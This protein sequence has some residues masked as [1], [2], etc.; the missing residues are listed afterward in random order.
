MTEMEPSSSTLSALIAGIYDRAVDPSLWPRTLAGI[1]AFTG[2]ASGGLAVNELPTGRLLMAQGHGIAPEWVARFEAYRD[3]VLAMWGGPGTAATAAMDEVHVN[4]E[5]MRG[6]RLENFA[7]YREYYRPQG[8]VDAAMLILARDSSLIATLGLNWPEGRGP[9]SQ[10]QRN[11]LLLLLPHLQRAM[12]ISNLLDRQTLAQASLTATLNAIGTGIVLVAPDLH[13]VF[14]NDSGKLALQD[15]P[16]L[17]RSNGRLFVDEP[18]AMSALTQAVRLAAQDEAVIGLRGHGIPVQRAG[19][20]ALVLHVLPL[21]RSPLRGGLIPEAGAAV[22]IS[23]LTPGPEAPHHILGA[24]FDLTRAEARVFQL[25]AAGETRE[26]AA[27]ALGIQI[28]TLKTHLLRIYA[29]TGTSRA[30]DLVRLASSIARP[31]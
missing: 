28:S 3:D 25:I 20:K 15:G 26:S 21:L 9:I 7:A 22:F 18:L 31:L 5:I 2:F 13:I 27:R 12:A 30:A 19:A 1:M 24:L 6:E 11:R 16:H 4:S 8:L 17:R 10:T 23:D 29:K 14:A